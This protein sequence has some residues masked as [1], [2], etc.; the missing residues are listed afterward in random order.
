L[1]SSVYAGEGWMDAARLAWLTNELQMGQ[2]S[3]QLMILACHIPINPQAD[4]GNANPV[5]QFFAPNYQ[6]ETNLIATLHNYPNLILLMAGHR[7][8]NVVTPQPSPDTNHPEYGFWEVETTSLRDF[9]RQFRTWEI[10]RNSDNTISILTTD[11]DPVVEDGSVAAKSLDYA[12]GNFRISGKGALDDTSSQTYN[13]ELVK[14]LSPA[15]QTV[16]SA[17]GGPL[18]HHLAIDRNT[19]NAVISFLGELQSADHLLGP[20]NDVTNISPYAV[21]ASRDANFY[22]AAE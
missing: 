2:N 18:G 10:L 11:V 5:G 20:W 6:T 4:I 15:M 7:H 3:S 16:I 17:Y 14:T 13:A 12:V 19:T 21:P 8:L 9:P 1:L 22:R